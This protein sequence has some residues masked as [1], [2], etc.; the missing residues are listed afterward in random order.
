MKSKLRRGVGATCGTPL[1]LFYYGANNLNLIYNKK[2]L[3]GPQTEG[4][5][6]HRQATRETI[7]QRKILHIP[8]EY[9]SHKKSLSSLLD[10]ALSPRYRQVEFDVVDLFKKNGYEI[11][12]NTKFNGKN[13]ED[14]G[15]D[16]N[17]SLTTNK[18]GI[19]EHMTNITGVSMPEK[20]P[21]GQILEKDAPIVAKTINEHGGDSIYLLETH[22]QKARFISW[23]LSAHNVKSVYQLND[24]I[25]RVKKG[26]LT[27]ASQES[28]ERWYFQEYVENPSDYNTS[29]RI[30]ADG[31]GKVHYGVLIRSA[32]KKGIKKIKDV[33]EILGVRLNAQNFI[34][35]ATLGGIDREILLNSPYSPLY[36]G[37]R[38]IVSN[39]L[40]G[41]KIIPLNGSKVEDAEDRKIL[42]V[43]G[44]NP[45]KPSIP[46]KLIRIASK[47]GTE[48]RGD[49]PFVGVDL[50][51]RKDGNFNYLETNF[52][53]IVAPE[54]IG[55]PAN[56]SASESHLKLLEKILRGS[57][58]KS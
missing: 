11:S 46:E 52:G 5:A 49:Y 32:E 1:E 4:L 45:D 10:Q 19:D 12:R 47:I 42:L 8:Q 18:L 31:F 25:K 24:L 2:M 33:M 7:S 9:A 38:S 51:L 44:I 55:L 14:F 34:D 15:I 48:S 39:A 54:L 53:P 30:M 13:L 17:L 58:K 20:I 28:D 50:I 26:D 40:K 3:D 27:P 37:A 43:H 36:L 41:G 29:F 22:E 23:L 16:S 56:T 57:S 35:T 21:F 6:T